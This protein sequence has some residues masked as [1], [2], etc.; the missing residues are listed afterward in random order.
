MKERADFERGAVR[1]FGEAHYYSFGL[2]LG[3]SNLMRNGF[4]LG[5][6]KTIGK[7][8]QPINSYSRFPEY[9]WM[10]RAIRNY[11]NTR[12]PNER[13]RILDVGSPKCF[14][15]YL[16]HTLAIAIEMT[17]ISALNLD[18]YKTMWRAIE[19]GAQG[20]ATF[21]LQDARALGYDANC[22]DVVYSM[23]VIEHIDG[24]DGE[25]QGIRELLRVLKPGG[26]LL[27][28]APFGNQY[29]EQR[30]AGLAEAIRRTHEDEMH[31]FQRIYDKNALEWRVVKRL[32]KAGAIEG[33]TVWRNPHLC[34]RILNLMSE[35]TRGLFG[36]V[37]P[38]VSRKV[39]RCSY[40]IEEIVPSNYGNVH[41]RTDIYGDVI[42][43]LRKAAAFGGD[44]GD[45]GK[46]EARSLVN[47]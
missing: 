15:L 14:G 28:S 34:L 35:N 2:W 24:P 29:V 12:S 21:S 43:I 13:L 40:G 44:G 17:D 47:G 42:L 37:N 30:R 3:L 26:L 19:L 22:F 18:E 11:A 10:D 45:A 16:A 27:L 32:S 20:T 4:S 36:F 41:S 23:S 1:D 5:V 9:Y 6:R 31:F 46:I 33:W 39:N 8:T 25:C 38:W 7:I